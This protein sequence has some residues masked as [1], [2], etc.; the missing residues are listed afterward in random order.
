MRTEPSGPL[1]RVLINDTRVG[2]GY[3]S[4]RAVI[5]AV[6][7]ETGLHGAGI[8]GNRPPRSSDPE[9]GLL[10]VDVMNH[11]DGGDISRVPARRS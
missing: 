5:G 3:P 8:R 10:K 4:G 2:S 6:L 1:T 7:S 11:R 9:K